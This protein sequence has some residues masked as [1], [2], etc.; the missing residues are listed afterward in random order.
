MVTAILQS[1]LNK[2]TMP[3]DFYT[4][5][6]TTK[7]V[8]NERINREMIKIPPDIK[9]ADVLLV[10]WPTLSIFCVGQWRI[11]NKFMDFV[12]QQT[13]LG[14]IIGGC[15]NNSKNIIKECCNV[16]VLHNALKKFWHIEE[17]RS[18]IH[19]SKEEIL[20]ETTSKTILHALV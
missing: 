12:L 2:Y 5:P 19:C 18:Q 14:L 11:N 9:L 10:S 20:Y 1:T 4:I 13:R 8:P 7:A 3:L 15:I 6:C 16:T 17:G